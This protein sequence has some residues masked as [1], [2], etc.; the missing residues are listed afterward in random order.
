MR[1]W[2]Y[3]LLVRWHIEAVLQ[4]LFPAGKALASATFGLLVYPEILGIVSNPGPNLVAFA[5]KV[6]LFCRFAAI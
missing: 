1:L 4:L 5:H 2:E 6:S 3:L